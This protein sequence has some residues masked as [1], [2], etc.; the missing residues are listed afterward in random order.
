M[1]LILKMGK[2][3]L[4]RLYADDQTLTFGSEIDLQ[5]LFYWLHETTKNL[6]IVTKFEVDAPY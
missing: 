6:N 4:L 3:K 1:A 5:K 2:W